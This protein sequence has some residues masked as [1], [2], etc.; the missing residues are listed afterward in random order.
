[1]SES[2][3]NIA[4]EY[5]ADIDPEYT[6]SVLKILSAYKAKSVEKKEKAHNG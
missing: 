5:L 3:I 1:M 6:N 2:A 4:A